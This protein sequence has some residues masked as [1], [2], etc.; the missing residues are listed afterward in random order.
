MLEEPS[1]SRQ[2]VARRLQRA[3]ALER[4]GSPLRRGLARLPGPPG[5]ALAS[6][7]L[8]A[9]ERAARLDELIRRVG[10]TPYP[11]GRIGAPIARRLAATLA[12]ASVELGWRAATRLAAHTLSE[13]ASLAAFIDG[14]AGIPDDI[15]AALAPLRDQV[16]DEMNRLRAVKHATS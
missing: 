15:G 10:S 1:L 12:R 2:W 16:E 14:A 13:Y 8:A 6:Q 7:A 9:E 4:W 11:A 3:L 5:E